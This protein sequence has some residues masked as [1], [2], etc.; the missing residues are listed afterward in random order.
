M[1]EHAKTDSKYDSLENIP[2]EDEEPSQSSPEEDRDGT[3]STTEEPDSPKE[4]LCNDRS[5]E[6][7][8]TDESQCNE[9][10]ADDSTSYSNGA[11]VN[12]NHDVSCVNF[13]PP[14]FGWI[15]SPSRYYDVS[16]MTI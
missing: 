11:A 14:I 10:T 15:R 5:E 2:E 13:E 4:G 6:E 7:E 16:F 12:Q 9:Y 8:K 1:A 3:N